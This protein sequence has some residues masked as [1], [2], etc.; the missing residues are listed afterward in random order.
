MR[1][2]TGIYDADYR[3]A[4]LLLIS[5]VATLW[6]SAASAQAVTAAEIKREGIR[7]CESLNLGNLR[8]DQ[9]SA[10][11]LTPKGYYGTSGVP[12]WQVDVSAASVHMVF[13]TDGQLWRLTR[14]LQVPAGASML[15]LESL[16]QRAEATNK[17]L[18]QD[19]LEFKRNRVTINNEDPRRMQIPEAQDRVELRWCL[20]LGGCPTEAEVVATVTADKG[21]LCEWRA[22]VPKSYGPSTPKL[23]EE[24]AKERA[25]AF[26][27]AV[28]T[29]RPNERK[30]YEQALPVFQSQTPTLRWSRGG[31]GGPGFD[32]ARH[33]FVERELR[34]VYDFEAPTAWVE[35]DAD[36]GELQSI[37]YGYAKS[38]EAASKTPQASNP[39]DREPPV[40]DPPSPKAPLVAIGAIGAGLIA[41]AV[42]KYL[43]R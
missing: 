17:L 8:E 24:Q 5:A 10:E 39:S 37:G 2:P 1:R 20:D 31:G 4:R 6:P 23:S 32:Q 40:A 19:L 42:V 38:S 3:V 29:A 12:Y 35:I 9:L 36:T 15:P 28:G 18:R 34:L 41:I 13:S 16:W 11:L 21:E 43:R 14:H 7:I 22:F 25:A 27:Q 26:L 33:Y 30:Y